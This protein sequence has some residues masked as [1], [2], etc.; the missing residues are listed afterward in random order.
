M[1]KFRNFFI[2][3]MAALAIAI[4]GSASAGAAVNAKPTAPHTATATVHES[5]KSRAA[6]PDIIEGCTFVAETPFQI[7]AGGKWYGEGKITGCTVPAPL[8]CNM[9]VQLQEWEGQEDGSYEWIIVSSADKNIPCASGK[10]FQSPGYQC[11][12]IAF[13]NTFQTY[14]QLIV[15]DGEGDTGSNDTTSASRVIP[16]E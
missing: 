2:A 3:I 1:N 13:D 11:L 4:I 16:C 12:N 5:T 9:D 8:T 10:T 7:T 15:A 14:V 6:S